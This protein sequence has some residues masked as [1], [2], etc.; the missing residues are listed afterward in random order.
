M[1]DLQQEIRKL[2]PWFHNIH[3]PDG[4]QTAPEHFLGDFPSFKWEILKD[5]IPE[6]L[7]TWSALDIGCNAGFYTLELAKRGAKVVGIDLDLHYLNQAKWV[8]KNFGF[9]H[10]VKLKNKQVYDLAKDETKYDL[11]WFMGVFYHLRYPL[12]AL[13]II[14]QKTNKLLVFQSLTMPGDEPH[15]ISENYKINDREEMLRNSWPKLAFIEQKLNN[16]PT[17]WWAPNP[18]CVEAMMRSS[19]FKIIA[20]PGH[21]MYICIPDSENPPVAAT[22]NRS[23]YLSAIGKE[24]KNTLSIKTGF[25]N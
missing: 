17:N 4:S 23:E 22:W 8:M 2:E 14:A 10:K 25:H 1:V 12:L 5:Y 20:R 15:I 24:W 6:D 18:A 19:G 16:D 3:L 7:S 11:V 13:D 21:E 9:Q